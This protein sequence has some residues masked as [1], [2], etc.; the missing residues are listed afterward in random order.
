MTIGCDAH[1][2]MDARAR[3][4]E[5]G[6]LDGIARRTFIVQSALMA[7]AAA[8]AACGGDV[9]TAPTIP[10]T[11]SDN[12]ITIAS[13]PALSTVGGVAVLSI[14]NVPLAIVRTGDTSFLA[15]SRICPHQGGTVQQSGSGFQ[16]PVH[17][18]QF[19]STG[20]WVGGQRTTNL[21]AYTT[22]YDATAGTL[23]V[24]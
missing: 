12:T 5:P 23:T 22:S 18:A 10:T 2:C 4:I 7:A 19:S 16:C 6:T 24:S 17:G 20:Q 3:H 9:S 15:L 14:G 8:L 11:G 21:H 1:S 13:Y